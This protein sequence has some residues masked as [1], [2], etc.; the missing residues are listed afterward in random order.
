MLHKTE[1]KEQVKP[2]VKGKAMA[3]KPE[4]IEA[5]TALNPMDFQPYSEPGGVRKIIEGKKN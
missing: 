1:L 4:T 3:A 5:Y 2:A